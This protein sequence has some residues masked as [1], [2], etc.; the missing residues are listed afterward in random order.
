MSLILLCFIILIPFN[1]SKSSENLRLKWS[2]I[3]SRRQTFDKNCRDSLKKCEI[4]KTAGSDIKTKK[5]EKIK[6][7]RKNKKQR[8]IS[9]KSKEL[10]IKINISE[11]L[12]ENSNNDLDKRRT[13]KNDT[14]EK[15]SKYSTNI[16]TNK[17]IP[18]IKNLSKFSQKKSNIIKISNLRNSTKTSKPNRR[19]KK[20][21]YKS[22]S[23]DLSSLNSNSKLKNSNNDMP[24]YKENSNPILKNNID[25]N[26][27]KRKSS[28]IEIQN[29]FLEKCIKFIPKEERSN[30]FIEEEL[31]KMDYKYAIELDKRDFITYYF[32][33]LKLKH[34]KYFFVIMIKDLINY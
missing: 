18:K 14:L 21:F 12:E 28:K 1:L 17:V 22:L 11:T 10:K 19:K 26:E 4:N 31:N 29:K 16:N 2:K 5:V 7:N 23:M 25:L 6:R 24:F 34:L 9:R 15:D 8:R 13:L 32:S 27:T 3:I 33:L 20:I 30:I